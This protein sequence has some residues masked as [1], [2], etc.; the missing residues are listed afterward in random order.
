MLC[1]AAASR[2]LNR[3]F[4]IPRNFFPIAM[5]FLRRV[6]Y[7]GGARTCPQH[8]RAPL[9]CL[10][11]ARRAAPCHAVRVANASLAA[12][13]C[14]ADSRG[15][16]EGHQDRGGDPRI[17][18]GERDRASPKKSSPK[19]ALNRKTLY[20]VVNHRNTHSSPQTGQPHNVGASPIVSSDSA[21]GAI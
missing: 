3:A 17:R 21:G 1:R 5:G 18:G 2:V 13:A 6:P 10:P 8:S 14:S 7:I 20:T 4:P 15:H 11:A 19:T 16:R 9:R 12:R